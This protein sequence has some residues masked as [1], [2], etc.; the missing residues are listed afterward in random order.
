MN[1][2]TDNGTE[3]TAP[4]PQITKGSGPSLV[5]LIPAVTAIIGGWIIFKTLSEKGPEISITFRSAEGIEAGKTKIKY[6]DIEI[7]IVDSVHFG[8]DFDNVILT[9]SITK[10]AA[11]FM[12]RDTRFWLVKPRVTMRG[13]S[14]LSTLIS[15]VYVEIEPGQGAPHKNFIGL[16]VAPV[17]KAD[18]AGRKIVLLA[19][20]LGSIDT[21]S[22]VYHQGL[23]A[24]EVLGYEIGSDRKSIFIHAF[25]KSPYDEIIHSNTRF[26][27]VSGMDVWVG[28]DGIKIHA[29]S[30]QTILYGGIAFDTQSTVENA[31]EDLDGLIFTLYDNF[32]SIEEEAF[33]KKMMFVLFFEGS[34][35]GLDVGAP[36]E[37]KGI[38]I[39]SVVDV[40]LEFNRS[41]STFKIPVLVE[42]EP[43]RVI[44][45][46]DSDEIENSSPVDTLNDLVDHGLKAQ[47][48]TS[49]L[50]TGQLYVE[51]D[52]Y[53]DRPINLRKEGGRY[54]EL[55]TIKSKTFE[56]TANSAKNVIA[57]IEEMEL[58]KISDEFLG[59]I[60]G[61]NKLVNAPKIK[62]IIS[63][64]DKAINES[65]LIGTIK[66]ANKVMTSPELE[67]ALTDLKESLRT[68]KSIAQKV[69]K[70]IEPI[71]IN[72]ENAIKSGQ[73]TLEKTHLTMELLNLVLDPNSPFQHRINRLTEE[74]DETAR[75]IRI[76]VDM[77]ER[78]PNSMI[79]GKQSSGGN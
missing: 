66:A 2:D 72:L 49:S 61:A 55:P 68:L 65:D 52:M 10:E 71:T 12:R 34:V 16:D 57:K 32:E 76:F 60:K 75:S 28:A 58:Q 19:K 7:G 25:I 9:A 41:N 56:Q 38:K 23:L 11:L 13:A 1:N 63:G 39:G 64:V 73:Q 37:F 42:I 79:F 62:T 67:T 18:E 74:L 6:K 5:W 33:S 36:V 4:S 26:W 20:K 43:E 44:G 15:G 8:E 31:K 21:G 29:E 53:P 48:Q 45:R 30:I 17:I 70:R 54:P 24:G 78:N 40:H 69:D 47:L 50:L 46:K 77:L 27:N 3:N 51:L 14:N 22:P 59:M 35:R